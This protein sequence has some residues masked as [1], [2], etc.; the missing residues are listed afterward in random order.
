MPVA[1]GYDVLSEARREAIGVL[2]AE[3]GQDRAG[4]GKA[5]CFRSLSLGGHRGRIA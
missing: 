5:L 4:Y 3:E 1:R 2:R